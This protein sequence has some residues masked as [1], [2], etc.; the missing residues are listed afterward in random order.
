MTKVCINKYI[1]P[2]T[3]RQECFLFVELANGNE[4]NNKFRFRQRKYT[5]SDR[6]VSVY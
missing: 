2:E 4:R 6:L 1:W 5:N 3:F